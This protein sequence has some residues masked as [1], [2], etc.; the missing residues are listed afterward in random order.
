LELF[1]TWPFSALG[2]SPQRPFLF[3][4][5]ISHITV[6]LPHRFLIAAAVLCASSAGVQAQARKV[7]FRTLCLEHVQGM[8]EVSLPAIKADQPGTTVPL[9]T[10]SLSPVI[11]GTF[12]T[13]SAVFT[14]KELGPDGKPLVVASVPL[15]KAAR[16]LFVFIPAK[17]GAKTPYEVLAYDDDTDSFKLGSIR[18]INL[19]PTPVRFVIAGSPTPQIPPTRHALFPQSA[20]K[21]DYNM[22]PAAVEFLG[23][24]DKWFKAYS[25]SWKANEERREVVITLYDEKFKQPTVKVYPDIPP[26]TEA[27]PAPAPKP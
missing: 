10:A 25:A 23:A 17:A 8:T 15:A 19:A 24:G 18:A 9:Y 2:T 27:P 22:Y 13:P 20:K 5:R 4:N 6:N 26:W 14:G 3:S 7:M 1:L 21:D 11:E 12:A 16:Q